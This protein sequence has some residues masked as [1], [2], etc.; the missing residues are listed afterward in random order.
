VVDGALRGP[1]DRAF[2]GERGEHLRLRD[3]PVLGLRRLVLVDQPP[4]LLEELLA[5]EPGDQA[6]GDAERREE[7]LAHV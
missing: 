5:E 4:D 3:V 1:E 7:E 6:R 2:D